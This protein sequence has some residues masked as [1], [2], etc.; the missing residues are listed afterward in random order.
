MKIQATKD[1]SQFKLKKGN[2][3]VVQGV[4]KRLVK[5]IE[6]KNLLEANPLIVNKKMEVIDG[7]HRLMAAKELNIPIYYVVLDMAE[8]E[9]V[10]LLNAN[11]RPWSAKN[12]LES[13]I[14]LGKKEYV[15]FKDFWTR[16]RFPFSQTLCLLATGT[17]KKGVNGVVHQQFKEGEFTIKDMDEAIKLA[18]IAESVLA[19]AHEN[20]RSS[21]KF[22]ESLFK[23]YEKNPAYIDKM[24]EKLTGRNKKIYRVEL[25]SDYLR[26]FEDILNYYNY[27]KPIRLY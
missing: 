18:D 20:V 13:Y 19:Y 21:A 12:F 17:F 5:S 1:Y 8:L 6:K 15:E 25:Q 22:Y 16:Y 11:V 10:H 14:M 4:V 9:E 23:I 27:G 7:Q 3:A 26:Q 24:I 2:R